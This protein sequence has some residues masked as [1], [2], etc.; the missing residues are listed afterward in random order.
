MIEEGDLLTFTLWILFCRP[1]RGRSKAAMLEPEFLVAMGVA[2]E[3]SAQA[4]NPM[5][6][7]MARPWFKITGQKDEFTLTPSF[8]HIL[9]RTKR[10]APVLLLRN[11][12]NNATLVAKRCQ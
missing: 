8:V 5:G 6:P 1:T 2:R 4:T 7:K 11:T 10:S 3:D 9:I 12:C